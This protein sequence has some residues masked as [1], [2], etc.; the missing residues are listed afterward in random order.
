M[1]APHFPLS[2]ESGRALILH[3]P[4]AN[5]KALSRQLSQIG[6]QAD[7]MWPDLPEDAA[8]RGYVVLF[9][10]ADMGHDCAVPL[11]AR[12]GADAGHRPHRF[13]GAG[14]HRLDHAPGRRRPSAQADR[15]AAASIR[16][17]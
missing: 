16:P 14:P 9:F 7:V 5:L 10:D 3:R 17:C 15:L 13:G 8:G 1:S 6:M 2:F 12:T 11:A 4:H